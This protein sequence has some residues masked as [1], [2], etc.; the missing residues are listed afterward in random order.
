[1][2]GTHSSPEAPSAL[3]ILVI[4]G[5]IAGLATAIGL[6]RRGCNTTVLERAPGFAQVNI[7]Y[8]WDVSDIN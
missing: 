6:Q 1:M 8:S 5:G 2:N 3:Q 7:V 4:G